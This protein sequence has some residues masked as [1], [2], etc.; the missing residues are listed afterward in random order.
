M[1]FFKGIYHQM[2]SMAAQVAP[3][4]ANT[5]LP[6]LQKSAAA[7]VKTCTGTDNACGFS[8]TDGTFDSKASAGAQMNALSA[9][10]VLLA[11]DGDAPSTSTTGGIST[12]GGTSGNSTG[13]TGNSGSGAAK[14]GNG[15]RNSAARVGGNAV[16]G[17]MLACVVATL[18]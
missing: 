14:G 2:L 16:L 3:S 5:V 18:L 4:L 6:V 8:W 11:K 12:S 1:T 7:A 13:S 10:S 17:L 15:G 9:V